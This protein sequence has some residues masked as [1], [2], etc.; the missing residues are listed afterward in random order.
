M[1]GAGNL[2]ETLDFCVL[3]LRSKPNASY[4]P[5]VRAPT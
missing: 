3:I 5:S 2:A 1:I 4:K